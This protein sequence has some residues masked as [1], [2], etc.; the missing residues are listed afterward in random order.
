MSRVKVTFEMDVFDYPHRNPATWDW[1][2]ILESDETDVPD[3]STLTVESVDPDGGAT[4]VGVVRY[5]FD[6][7]TINDVYGSDVSD[8]TLVE[9]CVSIVEPDGIEWKVYR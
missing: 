3:W 9:E 8:D 4:I 5:D 6:K 1:S 2:D 7:D